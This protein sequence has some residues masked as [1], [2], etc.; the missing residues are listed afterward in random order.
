MRKIL[1]ATKNPAKFDTYK[2]IVNTFFKDLIIISLKNLNIK[3]SAIENCDTVVDNAIKKAIFY[4]KKS[5]LPTLSIDEAFYVDY[6]CPK[7]QPGIKVRRCIGKE[8]T[9]DELLD[10][11]IKLV[12][13][14]PKTKRTAKVI[15]GIAIA[16]PNGK[17]FSDKKIIKQ[18]ILDKPRPYRKGYPLGA[19]CVD[20]KIQKSVKEM[21]EKEFFQTKKPI[22][23]SVKKLIN[24]A[25]INLF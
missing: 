19:I 17:V 7:E 21:N 8:A 5:N 12:K 11:Y 1:I 2:K 16:L 9:D 15:S 3:E 23:D 18:V 25:K 6:L 24:K 10:F 4:M 14:I 22:Y 13:N 20:E